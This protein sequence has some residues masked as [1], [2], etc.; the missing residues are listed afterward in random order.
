M[1]EPHLPVVARWLLRLSPVPRDARD[2]VEAD[3]RELFEARQ[4][5]RGAFHAHWRLYHDVAS[6]WVQ[7]R[8]AV[9]PVTSPSRLAPLHDASGDLRY[10]MRLFARQPGILL[11]TILGLSLGLGIATAAFSIMNAAVLRGDGLVDP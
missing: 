4:R 10:A 11:L 9:R 7:R 3:L 2:E 6:L 8:P 1:T 5:D